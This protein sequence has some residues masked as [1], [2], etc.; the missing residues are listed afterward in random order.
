MTGYPE[1]VLARELGLC[2]VN[3]S[4]ITDYDAGLEGHPDIAPVTHE[5]MIE[6]FNQNNDRL[7]M[8]L[9][10]L[11]AALPEKPSCNCYKHL[12]DGRIG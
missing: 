7:R 4:L 5:A 6:V 8:L 11:V 2:Y 1:C 10:E 3:I 9:Q 12:I